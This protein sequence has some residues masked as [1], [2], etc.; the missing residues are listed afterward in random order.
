MVPVVLRIPYC[1]T[2]PHSASMSMAGG[3]RMADTDG[4]SNSLLDMDRIYRP[5]LLYG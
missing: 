1:H 3:Y 5:V 4:M 2:T